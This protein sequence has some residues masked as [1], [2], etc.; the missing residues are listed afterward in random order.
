M[1]KAILL[2]ALVAICA[3]ASMALT[4]GYESSDLPYLRF[5]LNNSRSIDLGA[6]TNNSLNGSSNDQTLM[7]RFNQDLSKVGP[8]Q[9][10]WALQFRGY[11]DTS[12]SGSIYN[13]ISY[14]GLL[15]VEYKVVEQ[16]GLYSNITLLTYTDVSI[17]G[18]HAYHL[19]SLQAPWLAITGV[20][21]YI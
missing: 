9:L 20:R 8:I 6:T 21:F 5:E 1:K 10:G 2:L 4:F 17:G 12:S 13:S 16:V 7:L 15:S 11:R 14:S 3:T 18:T 19:N